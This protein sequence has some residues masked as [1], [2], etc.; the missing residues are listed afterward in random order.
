MSEIIKEKLEQEL[1]GVELRAILASLKSTLDI[2]ESVEKHSPEQISPL[3]KEA[4]DASR[5]A[6][7]KLFSMYMRAV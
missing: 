3:A 5:S 7:M 4:I 2:F 1:N 6:Y